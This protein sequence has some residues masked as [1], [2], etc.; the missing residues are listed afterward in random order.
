[1][2]NLNQYATG[3]L[4]RR[5]INDTNKPGDLPQTPNKSEQRRA[6]MSLKKYGCLLVALNYLLFINIAQATQVPDVIVDHSASKQKALKL[7]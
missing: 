7:P 1:M 3:K 6:F 2:G 5:F 4:G